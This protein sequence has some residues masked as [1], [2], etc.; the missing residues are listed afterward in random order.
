MADFL[1]Y[2]EWRGDLTWEQ[3]PFNEI[4][5]LIL[6]YLSYVNLDE[7]ITSPQMCMTIAQASQKFFTIYSEEDL[8]KEKSLI[9][10][11]PYGMRAMEDTRRFG[12]LEIRNFVNQINHEKTMQF[13]AMEIVLDPKT[14]YIA[15]RGTDDRITGWK[16]DFLLSNGT[17]EAEKAS[18]TYLN[19]VAGLSKRK[20]LVGGHSK[21][22]NLAVYASVCCDPKVQERIVTIYDNDGPG[23]TKE[24]LEK[25]EIAAVRDRIVRIIPE[26]SVIGL[27][28]EHFT[29]PVIVESSEKG[30]MQHDGLSWQVRRDRFVRKKELSR[31]AVGLA[32]VLHEWMDTMDRDQKNDFIEDIFAVLEAPG[33]KTLTELQNGGWK[34]IRAMLKRVEKLKPENRKIT[35][36]LLKDLAGHLADY[37]LHPDKAEEETK[38]WRDYGRDTETP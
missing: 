18:V 10:D 17:V 8:K 33:V 1:D 38:R 11:A 34:S 3:S 24:F 25:P 22:G 20:L 29:E 32:Q 16:E 23:F 27:L 19:Q 15:F 13:S 6:S 28:L 9:R 36:E 2:L 26:A 14:S 37:L 12:K 4:D 31:M 21:G 35:E 5:N 7:V 30:V